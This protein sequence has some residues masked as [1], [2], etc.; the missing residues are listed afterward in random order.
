MVLLVLLLLLMVLLLLLLLVL[1]VSLLLLMHALLEH[2]LL[3]RRHGLVHREARHAASHVIR[4]KLLSAGRRGR[5][6]WEGIARE[7]VLV[8]HW[9][10]RF[11][12]A[13]DQ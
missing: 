3:L 13:A 10:E 7:L 8:G 4:W 1:L 12:S 11:R 9:K 5:A 2:L 6:A